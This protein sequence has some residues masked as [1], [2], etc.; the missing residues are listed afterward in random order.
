MNI[1]KHEFHNFEFDPSSSASQYPEDIEDANKVYFKDQ[2]T[3]SYLDRT[4][5]LSTGTLDVETCTTKYHMRVQIDKVPLDVLKNILLFYV[6]EHC[7]NVYWDGTHLER[8]LN[9]AIQD[10]IIKE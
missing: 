9:G 8:T 4:W 2:I 7:G 5:N 6:C 1:T 3:K 10:L